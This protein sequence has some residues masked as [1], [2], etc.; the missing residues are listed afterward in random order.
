MIKKIFFKNYKSFKE[1][2]ELELK[3]ITILIGKNSSGKSAVAKLPT[4]LDVS[5]KGLYEEAVLFFNK[6]VELGAEFKDLL[7]AKL[8][9]SLQFGIESEEETLRVEVASNP[10]F[11]DLPI[12]RKW[13]LNDDLSLVYDNSEGGYIDEK[14]NKYIGIHF[15]GF[16]VVNNEKFQFNLDINSNYIGPFRE[17]PKRTYRIFHKIVNGVAG[18]KGEN[19]YQILIHDF[20][21]N[22]GN[23]LKKINDWYSENFDGLYFEINDETYPDYK[24]EL[25]NKSSN[26]KVNLADVGQGISQSLPLIVSSFIKRQEE[27]LTIIEQ[28]ELH[29]H[30]AA[31]GNL[32][33][34]FA[35][36]IIETKNTFLIETHSDTFILRL[37]RLVAEKKL[38]KDD[39]LIYY[40]DFD[41]ELNQSNLK[42]IGISEN[43]AV[44]SWPEN[45]F[46]ESLEES[47]AIFSANFKM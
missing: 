30:P 20:V 24:I 42:K 36:S 27:T 31:H 11:S 26:F 3:P 9:G 25:C 34:L 43:G 17:F 21:Y 5:L 47:K 2:Q 46:S 45:I 13:S 39:V 4:L 16:K 7:Y 18:A 37:R 35:E 10:K 6:D 12:I 22:N 1:E 8:P 44:S 14:K 33:E 40:V 41:D 15:K 28:P 19:T 32:A 38:K 29:L 23:L